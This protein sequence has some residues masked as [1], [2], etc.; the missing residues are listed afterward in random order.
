M[1]F[2]SFFNYPN[3][4]T[5][6]RKED[7]VFLPDRSDEDWAK[8]LEH[9]ETRRF[10]A[11]EVV[12]R[13]GE[14]D[15][16]LYLVADGSLEV[17]I[18]YGRGSNLR[19]LVAVE[20]GSVIGEQAFLDGKPLSATVRALTDGELLRLSFESFETLA[21][22]APELALT[23]ALDLGRILSLRLRQTSAFLSAGGG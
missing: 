22:R 13:A 6:E 1:S 17:L 11:G 7:V 9:I 2:T 18:P 10:R 14:A 23:I 16:A 4:S 20:A 5:G 12:I 19:R 8:L 21:A 3:L 15:R